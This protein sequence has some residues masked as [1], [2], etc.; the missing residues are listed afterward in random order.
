MSRPQLSSIV[1]SQLPEFIREDYPTFVA[2]V[3]AYYEYLQDQ[4]VDLS[5]AR[6][7]DTTLDEFIKYFKRELS[8]QLPTAALDERFILQHIREHYLAK[9][10]PAA[11]KLLFRILYGKEVELIYPGDSMLRVSDGRWNQEI[12]LFAQVEYGSPEDVVGKLVDIVTQ[13]RVLRVLVDRKE[14]LIGEVDRIIAISDKYYANATGIADTDKITV[15]TTLGISVGQLVTGDGIQPLTKV[16]SIDGYV[17]TLTKNI[18]HDITSVKLTFSQQIYEFYLDKKF[19]GTVKAGDKIKYKD[20]FQATILPATQK[21]TIGQPGKKFRVGQVFSIQ[22]G[23]GTEALLKVTTITTT[24]GIKYA[25]LIKFGIGYTTDFSIGLL[26]SNSVTSASTTSFES[27]SIR[28]GNNLTVNDRIAGF[29]EQG[30]INRPD[31]VDY[32]YVDGA[33]AG[34]MLREFSSN[35]KNAQTLSDEVA[36]V[37]ISLGTVVKYPGY[38]T[39]NNGF[40]DDSIKIQDSKYYQAF[41][42]VVKID[43]RLDNYKS[44]VKAM[45]HPAGMALFGEFNITNNYDLSVALQCLV[46]TLILA[47]EDSISVS[48]SHKISISNKQLDSFVVSDSAG[49]GIRFSSAKAIS[50]TMSALTDSAVLLTTKNLT[51]ASGENITISESSLTNSFGKYINDPYTGLNDSNYTFTINKTLTAETPTISETLAVS[52]NKYLLDS[53]I[54]TFTTNGTVWLN[55][56]QAQDYYAYG[57]LYSVG[58]SSPITT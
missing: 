40:I 54:G 34:T 5:S 35:Y 58:Y 14:D 2:F 31:Y 56:Y 18:I 38:Y 46:K 9:G 22:S 47:Y 41:S 37:I 30:Y 36:N 52:S 7:L 49:S 43:E 39:T 33:Y 51:G 11:F 3:E 1:S 20:T 48:E 21:V 16:E 50:E 57:E 15:S 24:G 44:A 23:A 27:T 25:E 19:Y 55:A 42:Y 45:V 6:D 26:A 8:L 17:V 29:N 13:N 12:S 10:S 53:S 32:A 28:V 4:G